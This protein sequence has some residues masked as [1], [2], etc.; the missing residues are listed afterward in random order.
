[1]SY[2]K[3]VT[4]SRGYGVVPLGEVE[5]DW[6]KVALTNRLLR[7][8]WDVYRNTT[9]L[10]HYPAGSFYIP[11]GGL[12]ISQARASAYLK[13][14]AQELG[15]SP[16]FHREA[17]PAGGLVKLVRPRM[18]VLF[19]TAEKWALMTLNVLEVMGFDVNALGA[20]DIR[21]GALDHAN[22]LF[23]PGGSHSDKATDVGPEGEAKVKEFVKR[24]GGVLGFCGGAALSAQVKEG[25]GLLA[26]EREPGK[27]PKAMHGPIWIKPEVSDHPLWYGYP[28]RGF[29]LAPWYG[30][31]LHPLSD[32]V[33]VLGRYDRPT[34]DFYIDHELTG[35][36]FSEYLP[37]E[38]ETLDKVYDGYANP[39]TLQ[40][41]VAI[42]EG[43]YGAGRI[44]VGYPHP[45]TPG[46]EGG[47]LL[48]A[49]AVYHVTQNPPLDD[50]PWLPPASKK[51]SYNEAEVVSLA[52]SVKEAHSSLV[53]P[54]ARDLVKFGTNNLYWTPRPHIPWSYIGISG[55]FYICE[56]LEAYG[57]EI[58]RQLDDLPRLINEINAKRGRLVP[59]ATPEIKEGLG[60]VAVRLDG[61][62]R[63]SG[64]ALSDTLEIYRSRMKV[65]LTDWA[66][67]F[68]KI[69]LYLQLLAIMKAKDA[70]QGLIEEVSRKKSELTNEYL[71]GWRWSQA[72]PKCRE[73]FI[74]LDTAS[75]YLANLKFELVDISLE[76]DK[77]SLLASSE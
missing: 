68:K 46:L 5:K 36:F 33:R 75:Y 30:K 24:G 43:E 42:A 47:F 17:L 6:K 25:W 38:I 22:I 12:P 3:A 56:R 59:G 66:I 21:Q 20:E 32:Q 69:L 61:V 18:A 49:N 58:L 63:L 8:G 29:P 1:M 64:Q 19:A 50:R 67:H 31:A 57:D 26:V 37:E 73:I 74:A 51:S 45:E 27:V 40:G 39:A 72:S 10:N 16:I 70:D 13:K 44:I 71:G 2:A 11:L 55:P 9:S 14:R 4:G 60:Q 28:S 7:L 23:I 35:S 41:M 34:D 62:Y 15:I 54:I 65:S 76:L 48:L 53:L 77:L 52:A